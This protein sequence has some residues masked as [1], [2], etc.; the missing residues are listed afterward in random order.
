MF[1]PPFDY[2]VI[3]AAYLYWHDHSANHQA[4]I[5]AKSAGGWLRRQMLFLTGKA[6]QPSNTSVCLIEAAPD[7]LSDGCWRQT[8]KYEPVFAGPSEGGVCGVCLG[9]GSFSKGVIR[10]VGKLPDS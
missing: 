2:C 1:G 7:L 6:A 3:S 4:A 5:N 10:G 9:R 8:T